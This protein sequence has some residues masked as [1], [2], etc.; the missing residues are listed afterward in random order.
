MSGRLDGQ[1]IRDH[2]ERKVITREQLAVQLGVSVSLLNRMLGGSVPKARTVQRLAEILG[3]SAV[4]LL[5]P[6]KGSERK[7][8]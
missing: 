8:A 3:C 4:E 1:K 5:L 7:T 2:L 6:P